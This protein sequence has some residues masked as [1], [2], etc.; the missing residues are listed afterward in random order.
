MWILYTFGYYPRCNCKSKTNIFP[1]RFNS[2][3][4][5]GLF[6]SL[7]I[8]YY[9]ENRQIKLCIGSARNGKN[10]SEIQLWAIIFPW[11]SVI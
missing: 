2:F 6:T 4:C 8:P 5:P 10:L 1:G 9:T 7:T 11:V 3:K